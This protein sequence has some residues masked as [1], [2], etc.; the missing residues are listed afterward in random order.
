MTCNPTW[1][2]ILDELEPSQSL[3][4]CLDI[5]VRV[6]ELKLRALMD[7]ITKTNVM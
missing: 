1:P 7:E 2:E 3:P 4:N 5:V 6:F